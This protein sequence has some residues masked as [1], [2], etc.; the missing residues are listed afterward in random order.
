M[1]GQ[2]VGWFP[3][4]RGFA[5][6]IVA[7]GYGVGAILTTFPIANSLSDGGLPATLLRFGAI[8]G[9]VG[10]VAALGLKAATGRRDSG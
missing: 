6:G 3:D 7:A 4:R 8:F 9:V 5:A 10:L 2:V 1:V